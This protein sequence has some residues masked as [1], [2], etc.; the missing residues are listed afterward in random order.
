MQKESETIDLGDRRMNQR[1]VLLAERP[2][3]KPG[4]AFPEHV[5]VGRRRRRPAQCADG[6]GRGADGAREGESGAP[7]RVRS[8]VVHPGHEGAYD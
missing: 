6:L 5:R 3:Q 7:A 8:G 1:T 4:Q 2:G